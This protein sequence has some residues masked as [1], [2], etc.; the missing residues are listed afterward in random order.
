MQTPHHLCEHG[1][2]PYQPQ[3]RLFAIHSHSVE[4]TPPP[5]PVWPLQA[6]DR[7]QEHQTD[8]S[9][10]SRSLDTHSPLKDQ[11]DGYN[12]NHQPHIRPARSLVPMPV[13]KHIPRCGKH[14][15]GLSTPA[16]STVLR[17]LTLKKQNHRL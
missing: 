9:V 17:G 6:E 13:C 15:L 8:R 2:V 3:E 4:I 7:Y 11:N 10:A 16:S 12:T 1:F 14:V 5:M